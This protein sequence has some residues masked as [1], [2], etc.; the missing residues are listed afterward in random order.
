MDTTGPTIRD[1]EPDDLGALLR[2]WRRAS[3]L[4]HPFL[5][6]E[7]LDR[8]AVQIAEVFLPVSHTSVAESEGEVVGFI[9]VH[10]GEVGGQRR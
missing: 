10:E 2:A 5:S 7:F 6:A 4:A 1:Y 3:E 9:S 8:E